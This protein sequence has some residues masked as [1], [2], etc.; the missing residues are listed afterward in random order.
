MAARTP[1]PS[2]EQD[3]FD[4]FVA[5]LPVRNQLLIRFGLDT[6]F[7]VRELL[8]IRIEQVATPLL[9]AR[10]DVTV[11]RQCLKFGRSVHK[12]AIRG[13][14]VPLSPAVQALIE[15]ALFERFGSGPL[16]PDTMARPLFPSR[17]GGTPLQP[18]QALQI[19]QEACAEAGLSEGGAWGTHSLRKTFARR[20]YDG[21][22]HDIDLTRVAMGHSSV[23]TTQRYLATSEAS[24]F[25]AISRIIPPSHSRGLSRF[26]AQGCL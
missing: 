6:G 9:T 10:A 25:D 4:A 22:G 2:D 26:A 14:R 19:V 13:R 7:R 15:Q 16:D 11:E 21:T 18:R 3:R 17:K 5:T 8:S 12:R 20:I 24:A 23:G 1:I